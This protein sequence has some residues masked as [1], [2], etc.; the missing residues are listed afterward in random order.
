MRTTRAIA[1]VAAVL[2]IPTSATAADETPVKPTIVGVDLFKNG[3]AIIQCEMTLPKPGV[4]AIDPVPAPVH[5]TFWVD[6]PAPIELMMH[7][8]DVEVPINETAIGHLQDDLAG[9]K[10]TVYFKGNN[11]PPV[12]GTMLKI[13]PEP[14]N[15]TRP[16]PPDAAASS[17]SR[18]LVVQTDKGRTY[19]ESSEVASVEADDRGN[20]VTRKRPRLLVTLAD[21][22]RGES[23]VTMRYLTHGI[24][25]APSY[26]MD[27]SDPKT[28]LLEQHAVIR[29]ELSDLRDTEIRL[30]SGY[31]SVQYAQVRSLLTP[32]SSW[33]TFFTELANRQLAY[34]AILSNPAA[35]QQIVENFRSPP[36]LTLGATPSGEGVDLHYQP[37]G[38][39]TLAEGA[40]L[41]L[42][43]A[44]GKTDY[45]R[46]V[47]WLVPDTRNEYGYRPDRGQTD[48]H[49]PWDSLRF[50]NPLNF[51]MTTGPALVTANGQFNGQR[52]T[53]WTNPGQQTIVR[54]EKALSIRTRS[55]ENELL[56]KDGSSR[57][58]V[59]IGGRQYRR[60]TVEGELAVSNNRKE[61]VQLVIRR[62]FSGEL[63][64]AD[65]SPTRTLL[66]EGVFSI[67]KRNELVWELTLKPGEERRLKYTYTVL[68]SN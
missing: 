36:L 62:Q 4:Y 39:R 30:I 16:S 20:T 14:S 57:D 11:R 8:R 51:P 63:I 3:L 66:Q 64:A 18:F 26:R 13:K 65:D 68:V 10:V 61:T 47:E 12:V 29:N 59:W 34:N 28:L 50:K 46:I 27:I 22:A 31:P 45:Q 24:S 35:T 37:I 44:T 25:W 56:N 43:V 40:S 2:V 15:P 54:V 48:D 55:I 5:G 41:A 17:G 49:E 67:N 7:M 19:I 33:A 9:K 6:S 53:Y 23:K 58:I 60:S 32:G 38:K 52:T 1:L 42:T 21:R